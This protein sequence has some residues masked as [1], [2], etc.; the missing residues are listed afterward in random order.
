VLVPASFTPAA[1]DAMAG[2]ASGADIVAAPIEAYGRELSEMTD[3]LLS[4]GTGAQLA[5]TAMNDAAHRSRRGDC[6]RAG[7]GPGC[8]PRAC[9]STGACS[10]ARSRAGSDS[11]ARSRP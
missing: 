1:A 3:G 2:M 7:T 11:S 6:R 10:G 5:Q 9:P 4:G 8:G